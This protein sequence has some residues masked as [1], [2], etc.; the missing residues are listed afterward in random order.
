MKNH[1]QQLG[2]AIFFSQVGR[3]KAAFSLELDSTW[4][5]IAQPNLHRWWRDE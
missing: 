1:T 5:L 4:L 3:R 2:F